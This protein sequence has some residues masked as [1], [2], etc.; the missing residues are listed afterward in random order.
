MEFEL[1]YDEKVVFNIAELKCIKVISD[2]AKNIND[3]HY[4]LT[5]ELKT[6]AEYIY[7]PGTKQYEKEYFNDV[8]QVEFDNYEMA[9]AYKNDWTENW[10]HYLEEKNSP[11]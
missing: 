4:F 5:F 8:I 3:R 6:R 1:G 10:E 11:Q 2:N 7:N 9:Q